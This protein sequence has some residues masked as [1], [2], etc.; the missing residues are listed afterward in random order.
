DARRRHRRSAGQTQKIGRA[1]G[2]PTQTTT[3]SG[4]WNPVLCLPPCGVVETVSIHLMGAR[5]QKIGVGLA[6]ALALLL[7]TASAARATITVENNNDSGAGSLRAAIAGAAA[8]ETIVVPANTYSLT[9]G[10]LAISKSLTIVGAGATGT[11]IR[12]AGTFRVMS[13]EAVEGG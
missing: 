1:G 8:G 3:H 2:A 9:S 11:I 12:A 4:S 13:V 10:E 5:A 7:L 6:L